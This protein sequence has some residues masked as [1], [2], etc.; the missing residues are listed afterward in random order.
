MSS[1]HR[2]G[3]DVFAGVESRLDIAGPSFARHLVHDLD[4][5]TVR[6][7]DVHAL[8]GAAP[9][10]GGEHDIAAAENLQLPQ[11]A[12]AVAHGDRDMIHQGCRASRFVPQG[13][14][15]D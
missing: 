4:V 10:A 6:V 1:L 8:A 15:F 5:V 14:A 3:G 13:G 9:E 2:F 12:V 11:P 7:G